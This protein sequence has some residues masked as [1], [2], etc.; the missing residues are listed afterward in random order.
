VAIIYYKAIS[1]R[2]VEVHEMFFRNCKARRAVDSG[3][4]DWM[5]CAVESVASYLEIIFVCEVRL[6]QSTIWL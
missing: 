6:Y 4:C 1:K 3:Y 5:V 2:V